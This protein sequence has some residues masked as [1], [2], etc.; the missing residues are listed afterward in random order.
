[1]ATYGTGAIMAVPAHDARDLAFA[2]K[3]QLPVIKVVQAPEGQD[4]IGFTGAGTSVNSG[5]LN[6]LPTDEAKETMIQWLEAQQCGR[7]QINYKLRDWLFSRQRFWGEPFPILWKD[8]QH[9]AVPEAELPV[10]P[11]SLK[12]YKPTADGEPPLARATDWLK[13]EQGAKRETNTMP[14]W[15]GSCWYYLRY[16]DA[17]NT[18][19]FCDPEAES[20]WMGTR[21]EGATPG[22]DLY[23]GGTE[24][25]VLHLLS[26]VFGT[27][28]FTILA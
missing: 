17:S 16:I 12:D 21:A 5:F 22:V 8:G 26:L 15:A 10:L 27:R 4:S 28:S 18:N 7:R 3:F 20:Y 23:V 6:G 14:Q 24:H 25:A 19:H 9:Q 13:H 11:P 1:L 2:E